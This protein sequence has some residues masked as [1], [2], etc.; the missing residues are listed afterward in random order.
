MLRET[1]FRSG[2]PALVACVCLC[3]LTYVAVVRR[4]RL[5][6][7]WAIAWALLIARYTVN[8][9]FPGS[10][11]DV[12][13]ALQ[14]LLRTSFAAAVFAGVAVLRGEEVSRRAFAALVL[15]IP[16]IAFVLNTALAPSTQVSVWFVLLSMA[17][18]LLTAAWRLSHGTSLPLFER[19]ATALAL[20]AYAIF[21]TI[22]PQL[23]SGSTAFTIA[24]MGS[25]GSQLL[26][27][28]GLLATFFRVSHDGEMNAR[29]TTEQRLTAALGEFVSVCMHCKAVRDDHEQWQPLE[30][31]VARRSSS[32]LSHGLCPDC[33]S[34]FYPDDALST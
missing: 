10:T 26:V 21:S 22:A 5:A 6:T 27:G 8:A 11:T 31:F 33:A 1:I 19:R 29:R 12:V 28:F 13:T 4:E 23:Q 25:W 17:V 30:R 2:I 14:N 3:V 18:L 24:I 20:A 15:G 34:T 7:F 32:K 9:I 16:A